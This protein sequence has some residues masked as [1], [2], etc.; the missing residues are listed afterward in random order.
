MA[1]YCR[2][3]EYLIVARVLSLVIRRKSFLFV[4]LLLR[5]WLLRVVARLLLLAIR[6]ISLQWRRCMTALLG[7]VPL[8]WRRI[9]S[10]GSTAFSAVSAGRI[11]LRR[12]L[13][14]ISMNTPLLAH[15]HHDIDKAMGFSRG[16]LDWA[17]HE[18][19]STSYLCERDLGR[20]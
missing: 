18:L 8:L 20:A 1:Q 14:W 13:V 17:S 5:I 3:I 4:V 6:R 7:R 10:L 11:P 19:T 12:W 15:G 9:E 16:L 2:I